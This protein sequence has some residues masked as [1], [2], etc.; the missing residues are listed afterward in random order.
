VE[1]TI[2][3]LMIE[4]R[5]L[6]LQKQLILIEELARSIQAELRGLGALREE[7]AIW[8]SLSDEALTNFEK[9]L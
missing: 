7:L 1:K 5:Q 8:D 4:A 6:P 3:K 9:A 2:E